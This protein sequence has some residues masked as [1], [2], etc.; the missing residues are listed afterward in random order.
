MIVANVT[1]NLYAKKS[2]TCI[3]AISNGPILFRICKDSTPLQIPPL[4]FLVFWMCERGFWCI[5][6]SLLLITEQTEGLFTRNSWFST[7]HPQPVRSRWAKVQIQHLLFNCELF[8]NFL[9]DFDTD[10][11]SLISFCLIYLVIQLLSLAGRNS[12]LVCRVIVGLQPVEPSP[13]LGSAIDMQQ[14]QGLV[15]EMGTTLSP[16]AQNLMDMVQFQQQVRT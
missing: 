3:C 10:F 7:I 5:F 13:A 6:S 11:W 2:Y 15:N 8:R 16:G 12:V 14:V 1:I 9:V 4:R